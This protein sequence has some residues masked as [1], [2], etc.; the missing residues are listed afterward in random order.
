MVKRKSTKKS[1]DWEEWKRFL[2]WV[3]Y[4]S[5]WNLWTPD[6]WHKDIEERKLNPKVEIK[7]KEILRD[8]FQR[9]IEE[10]MKEIDFL[11]YCYFEYEKTRLKQEEWLKKNLLL[12]G[13]K[14]KKKINN[15]FQITTTGN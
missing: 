4:L 5:P 14:N 11:P 10:T 12:K 7:L 1:I 8:N 9:F 3:N 6:S 2:E 13:Q 15:E